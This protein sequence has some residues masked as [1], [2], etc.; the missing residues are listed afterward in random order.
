[1]GLPL[2]P[3]GTL[4][5]ESRSEQLPTLDQHRI[6]SRALIRLLCRLVNCLPALEEEQPDSTRQS[7]TDSVT[8]VETDINEWFASLPPSFKPD[9]CW[10]SNRHQPSQCDPELFGQEIWFS[11][12]LTATA[13]MLYHAA[14]I[15]I[16]ITRPPDP[17]NRTNV[18]MAYHALQ[19]K[20]RTHAAQ[21]FAIALSVPD[22]SARVRMLQPL[23]IAGKGL[24]S[25]SDRQY[26]VGMIRSIETDLG[27][28][29]EYRVKDLLQEWGVSYEA[30]DLRPKEV[31]QREEFWG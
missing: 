19:G 21:I 17:R 9:C 1:M 20:L 4:C 29:T 30:L 3:S 31:L 25:K 14:Q 23:Y 10:K 5:P 12:P 8:R 7:R 15:L 18:L 11:D 6:H 24:T 26:L 22:D 2:N 27:V 28:M 13:M 16:L